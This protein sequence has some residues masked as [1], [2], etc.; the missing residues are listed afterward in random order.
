MTR[1]VGARR[2]SRT[3]LSWPRH[4]LLL[5]ASSASA[6][7]RRSIFVSV[8][9]L[10]RNFVKHSLY[11]EV[12][13]QACLGS[14]FVLEQQG[15]LRGECLFRARMPQGRGR[16]GTGASA[17]VHQPPPADRD[18]KPTLCIE[19]SSSYVG[20]KTNHVPKHSRD[21]HNATLESFDEQPEEGSMVSAPPC[22][23]RPVCYRRLQQ[24]RHAVV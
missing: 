2:F 22:L 19:L 10:S 8:C 18:N 17:Y 21:K 12:C 11:V 9:F 7:M 23:H 13:W 15:T 14:I 1:E 20:V 6:C 3:M 4:C 24:S 5:R 16:A